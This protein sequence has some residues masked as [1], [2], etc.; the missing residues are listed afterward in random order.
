MGF[1]SGFFKKLRALVLVSALCL[2]SAPAAFAEGEPLKVGVDDF[3]PPF[4]YLDENGERTGFDVDIANALCKQLE[5][6]CDLQVMTFEEFIPRLVNGEIDIV[7]AGLGATAERQQVVDFTDRYFRSHSIFVEREDARLDLSLQTLSGKRLA[8][9]SGTIQETYLH[10]VYG[11]VA[12]IITVPEYDQVF[13]YLKSGRVDLI[14]V[15]GLPGYH[16]LRSEHGQG[17][18]VM[19]MPVHSE[20]VLDSSCI[21]VSKKQSALVPQLNQAIQDIRR[22]GEYDRINRKYFDFNV[23]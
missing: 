1:V 3:Y 19:G 5:R 4:S 2:L 7:V 22:S 8:T 10:N 12:E 9:Q 6:P 14:F 13:E 18:E 15:D 21:A 20:V 16:Y 11:D 23:Y 17:L